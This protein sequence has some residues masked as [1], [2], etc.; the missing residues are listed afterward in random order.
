MSTSREY[1]GRSDIYYNDVSADCLW[2]F[3][4][5][6][7]GLGFSSWFVYLLPS[8]ILLVALRMH[9]LR[10]RPLPPG[11]PGLPF[12]GNIFQ[13]PSRMAW[14]KFV[15]W[16]Q[17]YGPIFSVNVAGQPVIVLN[18]FKVAA[19]LLERRSNVYSGRP[20]LVMAGE[21]LTDGM[22]PTLTPYGE[23][24]RRIRRALHESFSARAVQK[25]QAVQA[26]EAGF[27]TMQILR[28]PK[29]FAEHLRRAPA[30]SILSTVYGWPP[31]SN[32]D[33]RILDRMNAHVTRQTETLAPGRYMVNI[34][35]VLKYLPT[36]MA[37]WKRE[38]L[39]WHQQETEL[40][41]NF[42]N[43]VREKAA[44]GQAT[45]TFAN[46]L[47]ETQ[48]RHGLTEKEVAWLAGTVLA[49]GGDTTFGTLLYFV[50]AMVL[51][52][53]AM[54]RAQQELDNVVGRERLP[55]FN[56][57]K[58]L[59]YIT[60]LV[61][62]V[63]RWRPVAPMS[64][65]RVTTEVTNRSSWGH[66]HTQCLVGEP[67]ASVKAMNRYFGECYIY[68]L[69]RLTSRR[70]PSIFPDFDDFRPERFLDTIPEDTHSMG[71][72]SFGFGRRICAGYNYANQMLFITIATILWAL[73]IENAK[74]VNGQPIIPPRHDFIDSG[75]VVCVSFSSTDI[76]V[77]FE[78]EISERFS[79][80]LSVLEREHAEE[81]RISM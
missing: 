68:L 69:T 45:D 59:P 9:Y 66:Y 11:P 40:F 44:M 72:T 39:E 74:D 18:T 26:R 10:S 28:A 53:E 19:D 50:Q 79:G 8:A 80:A 5:R 38:G 58:D 34:F 12:L 14:V 77:P 64:V 49:A 30:G 27:A 81:T 3:S 42:M 56:D 57:Q 51:Y 23:K 61:K 76:P 67:V 46:E 31:I 71:H 17:E 52:P 35:P 7:Y 78:C 32:K 33:D 43:Q 65:P 15:E 36:W 21:I 62:E 75:V 29:T 54:H 48:G 63:L 2:M 1:K 4:E 20:R 47:L 37:K 24:W 25:Y 16:S 13:I 22:S 60:A 41:T 55:A 6:P 73:N 70:D